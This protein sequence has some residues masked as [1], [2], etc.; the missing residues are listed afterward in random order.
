[1]RNR[2]NTEQ[3]STK[4][5]PISRVMLPQ[6]VILQIA[7]EVGKR[8]ANT[9]TRSHNQEAD[10]RILDNP[11]VLDTS[12]IIDGRIFDLIRMGI[13]YGDFVILEGV[14]GELKGF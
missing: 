14:L 10:Q 11:K 9:L 5:L 2:N 7:D 4:K 6:K 12:A 1:M 3:N 8:V 13:F